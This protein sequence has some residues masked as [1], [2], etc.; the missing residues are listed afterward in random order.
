VYTRAEIDRMGRFT[1]EGIL[2]QD[3]SVTIIGNGSH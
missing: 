2:A 3:P 1:T